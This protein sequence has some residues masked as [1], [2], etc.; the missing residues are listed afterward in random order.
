M[1]LARTRGSAGGG[2]GG[3][4]P[5]ALVIDHVRVVALSQD[6]MCCHRFAFG[7]KSG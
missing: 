3:R 6:L 2:F 1:G 7:K 5:S 4:K